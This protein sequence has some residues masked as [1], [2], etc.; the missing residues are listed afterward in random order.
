MKTLTTICL[1]LV[2]NIFAYSQYSE[3]KVYD[4][5]LI[6]SQQAMN[7]LGSIVDSLNLKF[8][9]CDLDKKFYSQQQTIGYIIKLDS[10][11]IKQAK[12]DID[13]KIS[14]EEFIDKYPQASVEKNNLIIKRNIENYEGKKAVE[15][16]HFDL[17]NNYGF[18]IEISDLSAY[19][20]DRMNWWLYQ[21]YEQRDYMDESLEA[22][23]FPNKFVSIELPQT[24]GMMVGYSDCLIDT[25][26]TKFKENAKQG[27]VDLPKNWTKLSDKKKTKLL[28]EFRTTQ[29]IGGCSQDTSPRDHAINIALLSAETYNWGIFL[30]AH[31]D[32]MNDR[33][34]RVSDGSYAWGKRNTYIKELEELDINVQDLILGISFRIENPVKNHYYGSIGRLGRALSE[35]RNN[36]EIE[37]TILSIISDNKLDDYN[38]LLFFFLF[39]NYNYYLED[40]IIKE[41]NY[42]RLL[43][44]INDFPEH[45]REKLSF[46]YQK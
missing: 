26:T 37:Q 29:V 35:T 43:T 45:Y 33:F 40:E 12:K 7:K 5:G 42:Q 32:I 16:E 44:A 34:D 15:F 10:G 4:N 18:S 38:R 14:I 27:W 24:Y 30:K 8:K 6:Y 25:T 41:N 39:K 21:Y 17:K 13:N 46:Q 3:F 19:K 22:F 20:N 31:L 1:L 28:D 9:S 23:Y 11:N 36:E 2:F